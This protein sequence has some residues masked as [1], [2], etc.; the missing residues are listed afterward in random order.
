MAFAVHGNAYHRIGPLLQRQGERRD[1]IY[2]Q[3]WIYDDSVDYRL[4]VYSEKDLDRS[5]LQ[6]LQTMLVECNQF[7][8]TMKSVMPPD[9]VTADLHLLPPGNLLSTTLLRGSVKVI[10]R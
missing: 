5:I 7:I 6:G 1:P 10:H 4:R 3:L 8:R 9:I 2:A